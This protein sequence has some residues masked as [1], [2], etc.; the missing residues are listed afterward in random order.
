MK[1]VIVMRHGKSQ[2][3]HPPE[4][5]HSRALETRGRRE[6]SEVAAMLV[7]R[8]WL[9]DRAFVSDARRATETWEQMAGAFPG[10]E[11][12][13]CHDLYVGG[14][15]SA[16]E[17]IASAPPEAVAVLFVGHNPD[18]ERLV[19]WL[20]GESVGLGTANAVL[21]E[22]NSESWELLAEAGVFRLVEVLRP[23]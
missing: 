1:R 11:V 15:Q 8:G 23:R 19:A 13:A 18:L 14:G 17:R 9:P 10:V 5:D 3:A 20:S 2:P 22:T 6:A 7:A 16:L 12:H 21:L 4:S